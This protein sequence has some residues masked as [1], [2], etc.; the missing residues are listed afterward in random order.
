MLSSGQGAGNLVRIGHMAGS[1]RSLHPVV[2]LAALGR[3]LHDLGMRVSIGDGLEAA[4]EEISQPT[5]TLD[6]TA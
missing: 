5:R 4:L 2:G 1:A 6:V 3:T